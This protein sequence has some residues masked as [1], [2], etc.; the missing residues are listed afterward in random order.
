ME[1]TTGKLRELIGKVNS[2]S[3][4]LG[5]SGLSSR[6]AT[7]QDGAQQLADGSRKLA[8][9]VE[10]LVGQTKK[11][12]AG[13]NDASGFLMAMRSDAT[14][15]PMAGFLHLRHSVPSRDDFKKAAGIFISPGRA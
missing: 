14:T 7:L 4:L 5:A 6:L 2:A 1:A 3:Q 13:L 8:D 10:L 11:M 15:P 9:A 12:G